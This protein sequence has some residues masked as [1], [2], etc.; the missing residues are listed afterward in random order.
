MPKAIVLISVISVSIIFVYALF[1]NKLTPSLTSFDIDS[2]IP[3]QA[4]ELTNLPESRPF[5]MGFTNQPFDWNES[6]F[7]KTAELIKLH[8]DTITI[9]YDVGV[10]WLE[11]YEGKTYQTNIEADLERQQNI[12]KDFKHRIVVANFLAPDRVN[13]APYTG[14]ETDIW[15]NLDFNAPQVIK[16]YL[17]YCRELINRFQPDYF[18]YVVEVDSAFTDVTDSRFIKLRELSKII[19]TT[20][21]NEYPDLIIF[22]EFNLGDQPYMEARQEVIAQLLNYS[23]IYA[24]STYPARFES[25][26]GD[27]TK[28][29]ENWFTLA[30]DYAKDKPIAI[31]ETGFHAEHFLHPTLGVK[32]SDSDKRLLIPGGEKSQAL[33]IKKLLE[34]GYKMNMVFIN[35]W[36]VQDL[37]ALFNILEK[38]DPDFASSMLRLAE[39]MGLYEQNGIP[40]PSLDIWDAWFG[41][42]LKTNINK[43]NKNFNK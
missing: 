14:D 37:D 34:K 7:Q 17:N 41:L 11:S 35:L 12:V 10:P 32:V 20:L 8:G 13:L 28:L 36:T 43:P 21:K 19:Y 33:Y 6:A 26:A 5:L 18:G 9:F 15:K 4:L 27:A 16:S 3:D 1:L 42:P 40:R 31:L 23:D 30:R 24:L 2:N 29:P 25:I 38:S 39:N 22:A